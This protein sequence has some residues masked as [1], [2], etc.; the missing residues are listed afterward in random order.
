MQPHL[1]SRLRVPAFRL[2]LLGVVTLLS[3]ARVSAGT[4][5]FTD[6]G[7]IVSVAL[8]PDIAARGSTFACQNEVCAV[9]LLPPT[10]PSGST[11][12]GSTNIR[13]PAGGPI[14]AT[15]TIAPTFTPDGTFNVLSFLVTYTGGLAI[16]VVGPVPNT[17]VRTGA[18]QEGAGITWFPDGGSIDDQIFFQ[19]DGP[20]AVPEPGSVLLLLTALGLAGR[21]L[22]GVR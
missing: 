15:I 11:S 18:L 10:I 7:P 4:I 5:T 13:E 14:S 6:L 21:R 22:R 2:V 19:S 8:S 12:F 9:T 20:Q 17:V 3:A 1:S 16:P